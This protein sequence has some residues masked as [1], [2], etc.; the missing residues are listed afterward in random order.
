MTLL[1]QGASISSLAVGRAQEAEARDVAEED[2]R[3]Q[4][5]WSLVCYV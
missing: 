1:S 4:V 3:G 5:S 2:A